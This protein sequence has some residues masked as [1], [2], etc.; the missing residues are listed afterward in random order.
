MPWCPVPTDWVRG[1]S[2][3]SSGEICLGCGGFYFGGEGG[4]ELFAGWSAPLVD[5]AGAAGEDEG[6][7]RDADEAE[8]LLD[9]TGLQRCRTQSEGSGGVDAGRGDDDGGLFVLE[10]ALIAGA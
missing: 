10:Q 4:Y 6:E 8:N 1:P 7:V 9:I 3:A 2:V 5:R